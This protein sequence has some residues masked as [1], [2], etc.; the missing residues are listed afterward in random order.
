MQTLGQPPVSYREAPVM[1][2]PSQ[3]QGPPRSYGNGPPIG[4]GMRL[5]S[6]HLIFHVLRS[7]VS[8]RNSPTGRL[9]NQPSPT[10]P[11]Y[12]PPGA[13]RSPSDSCARRLGDDHG[14]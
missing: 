5:C 7:G 11:G 10:S 6:S 14:R 1:M 13:V 8:P 3:M 4:M 2:G 12:S 9:P